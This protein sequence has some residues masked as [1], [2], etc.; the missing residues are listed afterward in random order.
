MAGWAPGTQLW[1]WAQERLIRE[2]LGSTPWEEGK[3]QARA[4]GAA[5]AVSG[6]ATA[7]QV[8]SSEDE[9]ALQSLRA[10]RTRL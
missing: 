1:R 2:P 6:E 5:D 3:G 10:V 9:L 4:K 7:D 8:G